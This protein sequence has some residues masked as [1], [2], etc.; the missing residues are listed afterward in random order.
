MAS[1]NVLL[2]AG[3]SRG[4]GASTATLAAARGYD[5][6]VSY[7]TDAKSAA[8]VVAAVKAKGRN[9]LAVA[10]DMAREA[11]VERM[12]KEA[13]A[14]GPLTHFVYNAGIPGRAGRR[15]RRFRD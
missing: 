8:D 6:G 12:F 10:A 13:D 11:D 4:I 3:G 2:I 14:L 1:K 15:R 5:V 7:K 9:A